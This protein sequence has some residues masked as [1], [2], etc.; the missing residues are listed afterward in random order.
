MTSGTLA[1]ETAVAPAKRRE[2]G[3][4]GRQCINGKHTQQSN[5]CGI[6]GRKMMAAMAMM[7]VGLPRKWG[8]DSVDVV[9]GM[10]TPRGGRGQSWMGWRNMDGR[11]EHD[12]QRQWR[13][14]NGNTQQSAIL[15][16]G[17]QWRLLWWW[18]RR[19][20]MRKWRRRAEF[21]ITSRVFKISPPP[22][23]SNAF[24]EMI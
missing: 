8:Y 6:G 20:V 2:G 12:E 21:M 23:P 7:M 9:G 18:C 17:W 1:D 14:N 3:A 19:W 10:T 5:T 11:W 22:P 16:G 24:V 15:M 4:S 13:D